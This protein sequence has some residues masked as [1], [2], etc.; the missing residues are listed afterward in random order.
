MVRIYMAVPCSRC[1]VDTNVCGTMN[2]TC[3]PGGDVLATCVCPP[4]FTGS[5]C[6]QEIGEQLRRIPQ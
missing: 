3:I 5:R 4:G 1:E 2:S 6:E